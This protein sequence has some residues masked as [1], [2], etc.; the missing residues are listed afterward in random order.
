MKG[1]PTRMNLKKKLMLTILPI[2][3]LSLFMLVAY[4]INI[5]GTTLKTEI[6]NDLSYRTQ[7]LAAHM[8]SWLEMQRTNINAFSG[9]KVFLQAAKSPRDPAAISAANEKLARLHAHYD[10]YEGIMVASTE[11]NVIASSKNQ[12]I[13]ISIQDREYFRD[14]L[15]YPDAC[16]FS[17]AIKS[18]SSGKPVFTII[19]QLRDNNRTVGVFFGVVKLY[20]FSDRFIEPVKIGEKGY[21]YMY[22]PDGF[23]LS[24]P[25]PEN[26]M[27]LNMKDL[28]FGPE[29]MAKE[30]GEIEYTFEGI[31]KYSIFRKIEET[32]WTIATSADKAEV[33][34]PVHKMTRNTIAIAGGT[35]LALTL[36]L[37]LI[38]NAISGRIM[39]MARGL[40]DVAEQVV[41]ASSQV[42]SSSQSLAEGTSEQAASIE[43]ASSSLEEM[44]SMTRKNAEHANQAND[45][46]EDAKKI[47]AEA[48]TSMSKMNGSMK[49]INQASE[50]TSK[51]IKT[52]DEI[53]FQTNLL[54]LN[55]AVEAARA[56]EAGAGFAVVADE[57]RNLAMR[58]ADAAKNTSV[59][60]ADTTKKVNM[61]AELVGST[62][63]SFTKVAQSAA[64]VAELVA[65]I[66]AASNEQATGISQINTSVSEMD[67][68]TQQNAANAEESASASEEMSA[69]AESLMSIASE[70]TEVI[71]GTMEA[72][73]PNEA[74]SNGFSGR[75]FRRISQK[76]LPQGA[77]TPAIYTE[78]AGMVPS[79]D[80][81]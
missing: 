25:K 5:F 43:E 29:M 3:L 79:N 4:S 19:K 81:L 40:R 59:L 17:K 13:G 41:S 21:A 53:A 49:E 52:I 33:Y 27:K 47:V 60:I 68:V 57:V 67:Q 37:A 28:Y 18:K 50:E 54:A 32:G 46:M 73:R 42:S 55:A 38:A 77:T 39:R 16:I 71:G 80:T 7:S 69:Q 75:L 8:S 22:G 15:K 30:K 20:V 11:G 12:L 36:A 6:G 51:I 31:D 70:L 14:I 63:T 45:L 24:H 10:F 66:R 58:A 34:G 1:S 26:I 35:A 23:L 65:E 44:S 2:T 74:K 64:Q 9:D 72:T 62:D 61:G 78:P 56:G 48:N 76:S